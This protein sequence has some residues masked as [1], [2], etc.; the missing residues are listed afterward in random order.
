MQFKKTKL[1]PFHG[2]VPD[3]IVYYVPIK[4]YDFDKRELIGGFWI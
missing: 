1:L 3:D 4:K 2:N